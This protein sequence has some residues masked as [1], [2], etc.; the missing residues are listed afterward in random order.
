MTWLQR[1]LLVGV[2][3]LGAFVF[4]ARAQET[5]EVKDGLDNLFSALLASPNKPVF[6]TSP[7]AC[8]AIEAGWRVIPE[9]VAGS[10]FEARMTDPGGDPD[11][12]P[13]KAEARITLENNNTRICLVGYCEGPSDFLCQIHVKASWRETR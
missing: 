11:W 8:K 2:A 5:R 12:K 9:S 13:E 7:P 6:I 3:V 1:G 10:V 4:H